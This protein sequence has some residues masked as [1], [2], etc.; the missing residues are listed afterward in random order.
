MVKEYQERHSMR[1]KDYIK[2][3]ILLGTGLELL[4]IKGYRS[5]LSESYVSCGYVLL[6]VLTL[7]WISATSSWPTPLD[8]PPPPLWPASHSN[9]RIIFLAYSHGPFF[10]S[11]CACGLSSPSSFK[12]LSCLMLKHEQQPDRNTKHHLEV[13]RAIYFEKNIRIIFMFNG[14]FQSKNMLTIWL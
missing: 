13:E 3:L 8:I 14:F 5:L 1:D 9:Q 7:T 11:M 4:G 10:A 12:P 6:L 2:W